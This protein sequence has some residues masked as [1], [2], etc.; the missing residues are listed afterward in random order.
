MFQQ[1]RQQAL[2]K[3]FM[4]Y[5][6]CFSVTSHRAWWRDHSIKLVLSDYGYMP[7]YCW[8]PLLVRQRQRGR[9]LFRAI[10]AVP[11]ATRRPTN[12]VIREGSTSLAFALSRVKK[13]VKEPL[14]PSSSLHFRR[15][16]K[17]PVVKKEP[18]SMSEVKKK[19]WWEEELELHT[20][21]ARHPMT[22]WA[23]RASACWWQ[24]PS[25]RC[26]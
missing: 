5:H 20:I 24:G 18:T 13:V 6:D 25:T 1:E 11:T 9:P 14:P 2:G 23:R 10:H 22:P 4:S 7:E 21:L 26:S 8:I 12:I 16:K 15:P 17:E 3:F 19:L